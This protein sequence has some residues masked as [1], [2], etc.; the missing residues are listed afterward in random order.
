MLYSYKGN[1]PEELPFRIILDNG[2]TLTEVDTFSQEK[3]EEFGFFGPYEIPEY[4]ENKQKLLWVQNNF[5]IEDLDLS[6][7]IRNNRNDENNY[8]KFYDLF[9]ASELCKFIEEENRKSRI[10]SIHY[11]NFKLLEQR[12]RYEFKKYSDIPDLFYI[13]MNRFYWSYSISEELKIYLDDLLSI[14]NLS[15]MMIK[16]KRTPD[17]PSWILQE[18]GITLKPPLPYPTDGKEYEWNESI[19]NWA[20]I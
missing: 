14:C 4:D 19:K 18:D 12:I 7:I 1:Y 13:Q 3:L 17:F 20:E 10:L 8:I 15:F 11:L 16:E 2:L 9:Y 6:E 5:L